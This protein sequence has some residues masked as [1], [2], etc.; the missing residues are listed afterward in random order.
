MFIKMLIVLS[1]NNIYRYTDIDIQQEGK[2]K[3]TCWFN[4]VKYKIYETV[5]NIYII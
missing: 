3:A 5:Y 4:D 2:K 1:L